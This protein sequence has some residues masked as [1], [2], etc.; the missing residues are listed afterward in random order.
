MSDMH[1]LADQFGVEYSTV[2][3]I[4]KDAETVAK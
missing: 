4:V 2:V 1:E 3:Q